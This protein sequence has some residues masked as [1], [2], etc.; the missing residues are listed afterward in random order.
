MTPAP[1]HVIDMEHPGTIARYAARTVLTAS[2]LPMALFYAV[3]SAE[4]LHAAILATVGW[5]YLGLVLR[6][7]RRRPVIGAAALGAGLMTVRALVAFWTGST[8]LFFLQPVAGT[9][10]TATMIAI[11][12]MAGRPLIER[13]FHDFVPMPPALS[14]RLR[15]A[16][17]F[18]HASVLWAVAYLINAFGTVWLLSNASAERIP[19]AQDTALAAADRHHGGCLV[20]VVQTDDGQPGRA[21]PLA[22]APERRPGRGTRRPTRWVVRSPTERCRADR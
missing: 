6:V 21:R 10:A 5:Y 19:A 17:Y 14:E 13:L 12:A 2:V 3:M 16:K 15:A 18:R 9:I 1:L 22:P 7:V 4:G 20:P 11:T 8:F